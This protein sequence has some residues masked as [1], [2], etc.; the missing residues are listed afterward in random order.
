MRLQVLSPESDTVL[1]AR[2]EVAEV[3]IEDGDDA[4]ERLN[5][6]LAERDWNDGSPCYAAT[7]DKVLRM[8]K[9]TRRRPQDVLMRMQPAFGHATVEKIAIN[10]VMA[11]C[12]PVHLPIL[13]AAIEALAEPQSD[14]YGML[15]SSHVEAPM[16]LINGPIAKKAGIY[17][18]V[19]AMG[20]GLVNEANTAVGKAFR[21]CLANIGRCKPGDADPNFIGLPSKY[22]MVIAENE[23]SSPWEPY[24][25]SIGYRPQ[26]S[27]VTMVA[28]TGPLD[29][30]AG[31]GGPEAFLDA[32]GG[33]MQHQSSSHAGGW[34]R[35]RRAVQVGETDQQVEYDGPYHPILISPSLAMM[36]ANAGYDRRRA[37]EYLHRTV[38]VP[39]SRAARGVRKDTSGNWLAHLELQR[40]EQDPSATV[41]AL[42]SADQYVL[43]P[44][45]GT[46]SRGN[47]F[48]GVYGIAHRLIEEI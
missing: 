12:R 24:H 45:G 2:T 5:Q 26:Q 40:L 3:D 47:V 39:L 7:P 44:T 25:V 41:P 19:C 28:V 11:G 18:D 42:E 4:F 14:H 9:G 6:Y 20:P 16:L 21:L 36:L 23:E 34:V 33:C 15:V 46:A 29:V 1:G 32:I 38:R 30:G 48:F 17:S 10:A 13:L 31:S 27:L 43:F 8:L 35:G 22:G 37:Q